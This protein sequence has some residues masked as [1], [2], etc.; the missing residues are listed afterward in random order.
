MQCLSLVGL[1]LGRGITCP[2]RLIIHLFVRRFTPGGS[3]KTG[4][5]LKYPLPVI[6][7]VLSSYPVPGRFR[8]QRCPGG[9]TT[10]V[11]NSEGAVEVD[12]LC[13]NFVGGSGATDH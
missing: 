10:S 5:N 6:Y 9:R 4:N 1:W 3:G 7:G 8:G 11:A 2:P 13:Q 12:G